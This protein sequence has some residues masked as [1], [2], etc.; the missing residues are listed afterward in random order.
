MQL[1]LDFVFL[2]IS[3]PSL[4]NSFSLKAK[5]C[6]NNTLTPA[7]SGSTMQSSPRPSDTMMAP[8]GLMMQ[9]SPRPSSSPGGSMTQPSPSPSR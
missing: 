4:G 9:P 5:S 6:S 2:V 8:G 1:Y 7:P 3:E